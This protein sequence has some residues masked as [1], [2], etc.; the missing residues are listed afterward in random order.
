MF[1]APDSGGG[2]LR[3]DGAGPMSAEIMDMMTWPGGGVTRKSQG[4]LKSADV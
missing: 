1:H 4:R 3:R 2:I